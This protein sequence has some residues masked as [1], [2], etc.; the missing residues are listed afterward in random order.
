[1][2][3]CRRAAIRSRRTAPSPQAT[4]SW[5]SS[6]RPGAPASPRA[7][8]DAQHLDARAVAAR[9]RR[10]ETATGRGC[11]RAPPALVSPVDAGLVLADLVGVSD[12]RGRLRRQV[13]ARRAPAPPARAASV[14]RR[15][16]PARRAVRPRSC[17]GPIGSAFGNAMAPVSRPSSIRM[18]VT[19]LSASPAMMA[20]LIGAAP[21][22]RGSSEA[23]MLKQPS[24]MRIE[25][26]L[27][28]DQA[29]GDDH[30][31]VGAVR[32]ECVLRL[33]RLQRRGRQ[34]RQTEARAPRARP[35]SAAA[36]GRGGPPGFGARV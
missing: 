23:W 26:R 16:A 12:A 22:Q 3:A 35:A 6:T 15:A 28:Q 10:R 25:N 7:S 24:G 17:P 32:A 9:T 33:S 29:I 1:M 11:D 31:G 21:R 19:P 30:R 20:R 8:V 27:R 4:V 34:H 13:R 18:M 2:A 36:P 5:S 14:P